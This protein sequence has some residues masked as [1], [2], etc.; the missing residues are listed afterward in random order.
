[1]RGSPKPFSL[2]GDPKPG[3]VCEVKDF[4]AY[5]V[6][7][8][9]FRCYWLHIDH[10]D[11]LIFSHWG[12]D[13]RFNQKA[14]IL[15][16]VGLISKDSIKIGLLTDKTTVSFMDVIVTRS[17]PEFADP[18]TMDTLLN[19]KPGK[20]RQRLDHDPHA[21]EEER[22]DSNGKLYTRSEFL[23]YYGPKR[24]KAKWAAAARDGK[25]DDSVRD[26]DGA[27][28]KACVVA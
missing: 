6:D 12:N 15:N 5:C 10:Q 27:G 17:P 16:E 19:Y 2:I 23:K 22:M 25:K 20:D 4:E 13:V 26:T 11:R 28:P 8:N 1:M 24:G 18:V 14:V 3:S 21:R 9:S 7:D